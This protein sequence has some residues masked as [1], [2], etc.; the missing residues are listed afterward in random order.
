MSRPSVCIVGRPN[1]GKSSLLNAVI[2]ERISIVDPTP[3]VT[4]DR[5]AVDVRREGRSFELVDTGGVGIVDRDDL[6]ADVE[7]QINAAIAGA[8]VVVFL[9]DAQEGL[10]ALDRTA[11]DLLRR[12]GKPLILACNKVDH[13]KWEPHAGEFAELGLGEAS[14][15]SAKHGL[16]IDG[17]L[18]RVIAA[19]PPPSPDEEAF[20]DDVMRICVVG[21]RNAGKSTLINTLLG[22]ERV[23]VS[24][25][26]GTTRDAVDVRA[27]H[28]GRPFI[29]V[30]TAGV[31]KAA[32][33]QDS[34]EFY[35]QAR[36]R[37]TVERSHVAIFLIDA[38]KEVSQVD[39]LVADWILENRKPCVLAVNKWD[40]AEH[41]DV[42]RYLKYLGTRLPLLHYAPVVFLSAKERVRVDELFDVAFDL[43]DQAGLRVSTG[44]LNRVIE[45]AA[46]VRGPRVSKGRHP[47]IYYGTQV[48]V[49]PPYFVLFVNDA[50]MFKDEYR[51]YLESRLRDAFGFQEIPL[52]I[53]FRE[54][55]SLDRS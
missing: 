4:R 34:I 19:L 30:D 3:G 1:V 25:V 42:D 47:K 46:E 35:S 20:A 23:I 9:V 7:R 32:R 29:C 16:G 10:T 45:K 27:E 22:E 41:V 52:R 14:L 36:S 5:V 2:G 33:V 21:Q 38:Q 40:L 44:E 55:V 18:E 6:A 13:E 11:A 17:L 26:P 48:A 12:S 51:R 24:D 39:K 37:R 53:S 54:R 8:D 43:Y 49:H 28:R 15:T 50:T 31:R